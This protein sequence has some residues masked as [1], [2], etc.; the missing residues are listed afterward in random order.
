MVR[1]WAISLG[2]SIALFL[3]LTILLVAP[4]VQVQYRR[5][6]RFRG[7]PAIVSAAI[8]LYATS[9]V[10][11]TLFP[12]PDFI[13]EY[14]ATRRLGSY[15][16][17]TPLNSLDD[18]SAYYSAHGLSATLTSGVFLQ[19]FFN[20]IFFVP[21]GVFVAYR[22][23]RGLLTAFLAAAG[24][25]LAIEATQGTAIWGLAP[26]P[27][28]LA[29]VDDLITNTLGGIIGW[30]IGF[31]LRY[32]L[33][34][35]RPVREADLEPPTRRRRILAVALDL[36]VFLIPA[37]LAQVLWRRLTETDT[38]DTTEVTAIT[39]VVSF[40]LFVLIP[41]L[42]K[43]RAG[44]GEAAVQIALVR[45]RAEAHGGPAPWWALGIRW[46]I[47]WLPF[48]LLGVVY[49]APVLVLEWVVSLSRRDR[50]SLSDLVTRTEWTTRDAALGA[51]SADAASSDVADAMDG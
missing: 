36:M 41:S 6:G 23:R 50:R 39:I 5:F 27:Y 9:L 19:V 11:F 49:L 10:A 35:P 47:R 24:V 18:V 14:C 3:L 25:S 12:L 7:W 38:L 17:L 30:F 42:R 21:L 13:D 28:R 46:A 31:G 29:D 32:V 2:Y 33:P 51:T 1:T 20:V 43:D 4:W 34:D 26:C 44:P 40:V 37:L 16:T 48:A 15:V 45:A 22:Y 8:V